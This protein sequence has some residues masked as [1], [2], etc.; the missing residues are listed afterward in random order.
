M[1][2]RIEWID[3]A[4]GILINLVVLGHALAETSYQSKFYRGYILLFRVISVFHMPAFFIMS[5][6]LFNARKWDNKSLFLQYVK[7]KAA[8]LM[9]PFIL[10]EGFATVLLVY[11]LKLK[12]I[13][14]AVIDTLTIKCN[15]GADWFL[16]TLFISS[17]I[18]FII[19]KI[20][21]RAMKTIISALVI[22]LVT[23]FD[24]GNHLLVVIGRCLIALGFMLIGSVF[25]EYLTYSYKTTVLIVFLMLTLG[26]AVFNGPVSMYGIEMSNPV[27]YVLGA[28][29]GSII[30]FNISQRITSQLL[31]R[32]GR[33][34]LITMG[35]HQHIIYC[36]RYWGMSILGI[37]PTILLYFCMIIYSGIIAEGHRTI[38]KIIANSVVDSRGR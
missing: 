38:K 30:I 2:N 36:V 1:S 21:N 24:S 8:S 15:L 10:F 3:V 16:P 17:F 35:T 11:V 25:R 28:L 23:L 4:R 12:T 32:S 27:L 37:I 29:L 18:F 7:N 5:G 26:V 13:E 20:D 22:Y 9:L 33:D 14:Q 34:S 19:M 6:M 31:I